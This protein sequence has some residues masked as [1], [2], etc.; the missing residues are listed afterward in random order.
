[1]KLKAS[2][3]SLSSALIRENLRRFWAIPTVA[4]LLYFLSGAF[5]ILMSYAKIN[6]LAEYI[7]ISLLN[8]QPFY[9]GAHL[10]IPIISALVLYRYLQS[11]GSV[12]VMHSLPFSRA[13]LFNSHFLSGIIM[14]TIPILLNGI[15]LLILAKPTYRQWGYA[16]NITIDEIDVFTRS[17]VLNWIGTSLLIVIVIYSVSVFSGIVTGNTFMHLMTSFFFAGLFTVLYAVF[18][19]YFQQFLY[20]FSMTGQS[21]DICLS[22]SPYTGILNNQGHFGPLAVLYYIATFI[23]LYM[24]SLLLYRY[25]KLERAT[26][27]LVFNFMKPILC[28]VIAFLGMTMLGFYFYVLGNSMLYMYTG[29]AA[30]TLIFFIIGQMIVTK[31]ARIFNKETLVHFLAYSLIA[32]LFLAGLNFDAFGFEKRIP[33]AAKTT[34]ASINDS[35]M[36]SFNYT[37]EEIK[38]QDNILALIAFHRSILENRKHFTEQN[39]NIYTAPVK[40]KY[41]TGGLLNMERNYHIDYEF[42]A[43]SPDLSKLYES[44]EYKSLKSFYGQGAKKFTSISLYPIYNMVEEAPVIKNPND[45]KELIACMEKDQRA[46]KFEDMISLKQNSINAEILYIREEDAKQDENNPRGYLQFSI[47]DACT[48]TLNWIESKGYDLR[49]S[50]EQVEYIDIFRIDKQDTAY[51]DAVMQYKDERFKGDSLTPL[52]R[53]TDEEAIENILDRFDSRLIRNEGYS[54]EI[55]YRFENDTKKYDFIYGYLNEGIEFLK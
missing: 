25:R 4:F 13:G 43:A 55:K 2:C 34:A 12:A 3:F 16:H 45:I 22:I 37:S 53:I 41:D 48:N 52:L 33:K 40:L 18:Q 5:P 54:V 15:L 28:Y 10:L 23:A 35:F 11:V 42:F 44:L 38:T 7:R 31:T 17:G 50:K 24:V 19:V 20:G 26:D 9:M 14:I 29:F 36:R 47:T 51:N 6:N 39:D 8:Q 1:M 30:G 49:L 21:M 46:M 27:S 32:V